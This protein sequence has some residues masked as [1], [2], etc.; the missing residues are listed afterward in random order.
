MQKKI[1]NFE[2]FAPCNRNGSF[3]WFLIE[4]RLRTLGVKNGAIEIYNFF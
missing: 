3:E 2:S 1:E 4:K